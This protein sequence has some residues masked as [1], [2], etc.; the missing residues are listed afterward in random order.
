MND[1]YNGLLGL[2]SGWSV[3]EA[4]CGRIID[5]IHNLQG[6]KRVVEFGSGPIAIRLAMALPEVKILSV[7]SD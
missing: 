2:D 5:L 1:Q 4:S 3:G 7:E 6:C